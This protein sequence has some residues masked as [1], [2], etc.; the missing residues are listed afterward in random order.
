MKRMISLLL[1]M[2]LLCTP[3]AALDLNDY[4]QVLDQLKN[5]EFFTELFNNFKAC[6]SAY[7]SQYKCFLKLVVKVIVNFCKN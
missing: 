5:S 6:L 7:I 3:A 4:E 2:I 1:A